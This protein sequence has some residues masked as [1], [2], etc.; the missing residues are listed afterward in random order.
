MHPL[1]LEGMN[2]YCNYDAIWGQIAEYNNHLIIPRM[3]LPIIRDFKTLLDV[4]PFL[5]LQMGFFVKREVMPLFDEEMD[6]G[7][8]WKAYLELWKNHKCTKAPGTFMINRRGMHSEGPRSAHG[9]NW[10]EA[11]TKLIEAEK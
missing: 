11:V 8:D 5:T 10:R 6:T 1:A 3:Q 9:G 4:D 2:G 7:E